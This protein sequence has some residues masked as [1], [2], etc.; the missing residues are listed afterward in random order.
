MD[1]ATLGKLL[2]QCLF[3]YPSLGFMNPE[4]PSPLLYPVGSSVKSHSDS[5]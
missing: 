4:L 1:R 3:S 2:G 5:T